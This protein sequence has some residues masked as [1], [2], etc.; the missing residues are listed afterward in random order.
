MGFRKSSELITVNR[1]FFQYNWAQVKTCL[2]SIFL[3]KKITKNGFSLV[4]TAQSTS[5][6]K[7][8]W[9]T[10]RLRLTQAANEAKLSEAVTSIIVMNQPYLKWPAN[11]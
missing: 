7:L 3:M 10:S 5:Y 8:V 6:F 11:Y 4:Y 1:N 9:I 2:I